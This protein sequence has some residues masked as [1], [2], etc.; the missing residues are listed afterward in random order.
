MELKEE[1]KLTPRTLSK[2][3]K[4][5]EKELNWIERKEDTESGEYPHPVL[6]RA[7]RSTVLWTI[8]MKSVF[9]NA[10]DIEEELKKNRDPLQILEEFHKINMY[11]FT[12]TLETIQK[13]KS[14][15]F[16]WLDSFLGFA[17]YSPYEIYTK[18]II[19]AFTK[20]ARFGTQFDIDKL[21]QK[22]DVWDGI[23][24]GKLATTRT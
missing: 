22:H 7:T 19:R 18:E 3:L 5:L 14:K 23:S 9:D 20:A 13:N 12:L 24:D 2:H 21:R 10:D 17:F 6:Y 4:E 16:K 15:S 11:Y 1:T 8:Y